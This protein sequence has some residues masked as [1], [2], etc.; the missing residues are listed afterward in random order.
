[1][2]TASTQ[3]EAPTSQAE[4]AEVMRSAGEAGSRVRAIGGATKLA[5]GRATGEPDVQ[6][7]TSGLAR[8]I[9]YNEGDLTVIVEPGMPLAEAQAEFERNGQM[10]ALDP[11]LGE[12]QGATIGGV[13]AT[14]DSGPLRHRYNAARDL[15]I[16]IRVAL[17]DGSVANAGGKVIKNVAG[18][19]LAKLLTGSFGT[20]GLIVE[21]SLRLHPRPEHTATL[22]GATSD[23]DQLARAA[24]EIAHARIELTSLDVGWAGGEGRLLARF[25][26][27]AAGELATEVRAAFEQTGL[28]VSLE[29]DDAAIW[30]DQ[31]LGQR[32]GTGTV[33]KVAALQGDLPRVLAA[34]ERQ[35]A[36]LVGRVAAG[37]SWLTLEDR[38]ASDAAAA[39]EEIRRELAPLSAVVLDAPPELREAVDP[40]GVEDD[41]RL[42]LM[43]RVKRRFDPQGICNPGVFVGGI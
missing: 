35:R 4:A 15:I 30:G 37:L 13:I 27:A 29:E 14:G 11:P 33:V 38:S 26:G 43:R 5:W 40:W 7:A 39:V 20:L 16:G 1:M 41:A 28:D 22:V 25:G 6:I 18:Y 17:S 3:R 2:A 19:D 34:A 23:P 32:S 24:S 8:V 36:A 42:A 10:L 12:H 9:E 31:R 21:V